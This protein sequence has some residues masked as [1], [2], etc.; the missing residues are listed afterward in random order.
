MNTLDH[1]ISRQMTELPLPDPLGHARLNQLTAGS[2][3]NALVPF[4]DPEYLLSLR[5]GRSSPSTSA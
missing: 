2:L 5:L 3:L 4:A 1:Q